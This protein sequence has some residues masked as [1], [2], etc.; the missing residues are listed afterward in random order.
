LLE[1]ELEFTKTFTVLAK[2]L[3]LELVSLANVMQISD[4]FLA[5]LY[6]GRDLPA[7]LTQKQFDDI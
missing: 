4:V 2:I 6:N 1:L 7:N 3:N 5:D